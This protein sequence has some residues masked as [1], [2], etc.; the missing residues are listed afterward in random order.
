[1][2]LNIT[3]KDFQAKTS[4][5]VQQKVKNV[6]FVKLPKLGQVALNLTR[7]EW[8]VGC[9][10]NF[11]EEIRV[12]VQSAGF[13][14]KS[15]SPKWTYFEFKN[16]DELNT[17]IDVVKT[18]P[19]GSTKAPKVAKA[20]KVKVQKQTKKEVAGLNDKD[21]EDI[22]AHNLE[23]MKQ[24]GSRIKKYEVPVHDEVTQKFM[25]EADEYARTQGPKEFLRHLGLNPSALEG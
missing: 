21:I 25:D 4:L 20:P 15:R 16:L 6:M 24:V 14:Q 23:V 7:G 8:F 13:V 19:V 1:M 18:V 17:L 12:A 5:P 2:K 3:L 22:K 11:H 10:S 9:G